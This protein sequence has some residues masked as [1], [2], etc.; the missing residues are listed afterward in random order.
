ML[1]I[2][3]SNVASFKLAIQV[4]LN[5][6]VNMHF[7]LD[8]HGASAGTPAQYISMSL[9]GLYLD[10]QVIAL[11]EAISTGVWEDTGKALLMFHFQWRVV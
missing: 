4:L 11:V 7:Q 3:S 2:G 8:L 10:G 6:I 1:V 9:P 5:A